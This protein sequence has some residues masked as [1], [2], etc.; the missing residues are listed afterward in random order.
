M[1][2]LLAL[3]LVALLALP[4]VALGES[5]TAEAPGFGG[6]VSVTLTVEDGRI[7]DAVITGDAETPDVGGAALEPLREQLIAAGSADIDGVAGATFTSA[8]VKEAAAAALSQ[9]GGAPKFWPQ[10]NPSRP[11][12]EPRATQATWTEGGGWHSALPGL[13]TDL[14]RLDSDPALP[15]PS[16]E[17]R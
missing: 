2:K 9:A 4:A 17:P 8:A 15:T 11:L 1:K 13:G 5:C 14:R 16:C 12:A 7:V 3:M 10:K 6:P